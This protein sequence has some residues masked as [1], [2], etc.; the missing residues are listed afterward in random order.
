MTSIEKTTSTH[1]QTF[2]S[3]KCELRHNLFSLKCLENVSKYQQYYE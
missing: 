2:A 1:V 3:N